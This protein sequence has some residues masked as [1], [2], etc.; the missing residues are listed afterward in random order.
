MTAI[1]LNGL[2]G[3]EAGPAGLDCGFGLAI[4]LIMDFRNS[5][6][7]YFIYWQTELTWQA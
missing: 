5:D 2:P 6:V 1:P 3:E 7:K 4:E